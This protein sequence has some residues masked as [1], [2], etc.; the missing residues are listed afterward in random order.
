[1]LNA[2][3][4]VDARGPS[5]GSAPPLACGFRKSL[6]LE[7]DLEG[8]HD[9]SRPLLMDASVPQQGGLRFVSA[10]PLAPRRLWVE[11]HCVSRSAAFDRDAVRLSLLRYAARYGNVTAIARETSTVVPLP[12]KSAT[13]EPGR[14]PLVTGL[15]GGFF[16]PATGNDAP[17]AI[18]LA[19][20]I[21]TRPSHAVFDRDFDRLCRAH[22]AQFRFALRMNRLMFH[23][24][25]PHDMWRVYERFYALPDPLIHRFHAL[26]LTP[27]DRARLLMTAPPRGLRLGAALASV[28]P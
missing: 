13:P 14:S 28:R 2:S 27:A 21:G 6:G 7:V 24:F 22:G 20:H 25:A 8:E 26:E 19:Q 17:S 10:L 4:V 12:W 1:V 16:H 11:D 18:R 9:L 3:L 15:P 5:W 23:C